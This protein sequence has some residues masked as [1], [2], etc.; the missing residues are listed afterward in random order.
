MSPRGSRA[1]FAGLLLTATALLSGVT[2]QSLAVAG[3][4]GAGPDSRLL[5]AGTPAS[6]RTVGPPELWRPVGQG[7]E[8]ECDVRGIVETPA[9]AATLPRGPSRDTSAYM[10]PRGLAPPAVTVATIECR[11]CDETGPKP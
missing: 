10:P 5:R 1:R 9:D 8:D 11:V 4:Q 7:G 6:P 2:G 3:A